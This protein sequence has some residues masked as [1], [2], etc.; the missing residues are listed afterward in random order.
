VWAACIHHWLVND[1]LSSSK[2]FSF[3]QLLITVETFATQSDF[4]NFP[5]ETTQDGE[6]DPTIPAHMAQTHV[7]PDDSQGKSNLEEWVGC[8]SWNK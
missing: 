3:K 5:K 2:Y 4:I 8:P 1:G 7:Q 6:K